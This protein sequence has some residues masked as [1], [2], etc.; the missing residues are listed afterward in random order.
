MIFETKKQPDS[1]SGIR[2]ASNVKCQ[3]LS[4]NQFLIEYSLVYSKIF[5]SDLTVINKVYVSTRPYV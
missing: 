4:N 5:L 3:L 1:N 2:Y